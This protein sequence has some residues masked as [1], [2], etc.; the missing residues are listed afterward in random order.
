L[1]SIAIITPNTDTFSNP[2]LIITI[3]KLIDDN[4]KI[5][6]FGHEQIFIPQEFKE[7]VEFHQLPFNF[8]SFFGRP[9][10]HR[11]GLDLY[12]LIMQYREINSL[13]KLRNK[14][15]ALIC[16]DPMGVVLGGRIKKI[17][18]VKLIYFS[19]EIFF[20]D[21]ISDADKKRVK[22]LEKE[23]SK[24]TELIVIQDS[25]R[26]NLLRRENE[27]GEDIKF[28]HIPVSP[29]R[30]KSTG[31]K[32]DLYK[33]FSIPEDKTIIVYSGSLQSWS[34]IMKILDLFPEKWN[35]ENWLLI[36]THNDLPEGNET[37]EKIKK[38]ILEKNNITFNNKP[39]TEFKEYAEFLSECDIGLA[40]YFPNYEDSFSGK[41]V[42][43]IGLSSGKFSTYIMLGK[44]TITT[45]NKIYNYLN[46]KYNY[47]YIIDTAED[48]K[49]GIVNI[50]SE[51]DMKVS[52]CKKLFK[53]VL[54]PE[55]K[56]NNL[57]KEIG[58][59]YA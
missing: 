41:N 28:F 21:E 59:Y 15:K 31:S 50:K 2:T 23:Y 1:K 4:Y 53:E 33:E 7:K 5:L 44:P 19:F 16:I 27:L 46:E 51:Y 10:F 29:E 54:D 14:V 42:E 17:I 40:V 20:D 58:S 37:K 35:N 26:E 43:E 6:F 3:K 13:F 25:E 47:G 36:H 48:I 34:G 24:K 18:N 8:T 56:I 32:I 39:F 57:L 55:M 45:S 9:K 52:G 38:L 30:L 22:S 12:K 49:E 11:R